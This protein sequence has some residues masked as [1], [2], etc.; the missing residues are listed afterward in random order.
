MPFQTGKIPERF[1]KMSEQN[2]T[3]NSV[4]RGKPKF[5]MGDRVRTNWSGRWT[6]HEI[7]RI[8]TERVSQS[9]VMYKIHPALGDNW[10]DWYDE[11]WFIADPA[12]KI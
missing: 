7:V 11:A 6:L 5:K 10:G 2:S 1:Q 4:L 3:V 12:P 8:T 9:G